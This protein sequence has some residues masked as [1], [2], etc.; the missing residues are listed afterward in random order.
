MTHS[1]RFNSD[2]T[3]VVSAGIDKVVKIWDATNDYSEI[4]T[5]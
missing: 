1:A 3:K 5:L 4:I 2:E